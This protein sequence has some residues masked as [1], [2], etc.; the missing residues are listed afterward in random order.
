MRGQWVREGEKA[1]GSDEHVGRT[2]SY[3]LLKFASKILTF[4]IC[5]YLKFEYEN[6]LMT[7]CHEQK[8]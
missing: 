5:M 2:T 4:I 1:A 8:V 7:K 6:I 3:L